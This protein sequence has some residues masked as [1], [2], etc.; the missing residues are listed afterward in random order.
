MEKTTQF[1]AVQGQ[2][3]KKETERE[4]HPTLPRLLTTTLAMSLLIRLSP[5]IAIAIAVAVAVAVLFSHYH[6]ASL[7]SHPSIPV[8]PSLILPLFP[9]GTT[10][11]FTATAPLLLRLFLLLLFIAD[12]SCEKGRGVTVEGACAGG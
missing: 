11:L 4:T 3:R 1:S 10:P 7:H 12:S 6:R 9:L 2:R 5:A 8:P